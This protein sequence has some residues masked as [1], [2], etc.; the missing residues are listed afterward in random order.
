MKYHDYNATV[1]ALIPQVRSSP[2]AQQVCVNE[3]KSDVDQ[4]DESEWQMVRVRNR[5]KK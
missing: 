5:V 3:D 2:H 4:R 1:Y